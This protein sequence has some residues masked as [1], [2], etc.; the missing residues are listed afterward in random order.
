MTKDLKPSLPHQAL[1][2]SACALA[3]S[4]AQGAGVSPQSNSPVTAP[5]NNMGENV[6]ETVEQQVL[7]G[8][9]ILTTLAKKPAHKRL[10]IIDWL[11]FTVHED[12]WLKSSGRGLICTDDFI[13]E[14]SR[15]LERIFGFGITSKREKGMNHYRES[16]VLGEDMGFVCFGGQRETMLVT[17]TGTGCMNAAKGWEI[18]LYDFLSKTAVRPNISRIDLAHDDLQGAYI[19]VEWAANRWAGR[20]FNSAQGGRLV[21]IERLG[22]W[23]APTGAG[24]TVT[25][26][27]RAAGKFCRFYEKGKQLGDPNSPWCRAEV[28]FKSCDRI[29]PLDIVLEPSAYFAGAY[30]CFSEFFDQEH[31]QRLQLKTKTAEISIDA[32]V[33]IVKHQFGKYN[34]FFRQFFGDTDWLEKA[35]SD[36]R[37]AVPKRLKPVM[38]GMGKSMEYIHEIV[39]S[40]VL[41]VDRDYL[42]GLDNR[43]SCTKRDYLAHSRG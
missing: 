13:L 36:D 8:R 24:R 23:D 35:C 20:G 33:R 43:Q 41:D 5:I 27:I 10:A 28:E 14:A 18:R 19:S 3:H 1:S 30:P 42:P 40:K 37:S 31:A 6:A 32:A 16:W 9:R 7:K 25:F 11:N 17:L 22:N 34:S 2:G 38:S 29:I 39:I 21:N 12:T 4:D 26:G 15:Q